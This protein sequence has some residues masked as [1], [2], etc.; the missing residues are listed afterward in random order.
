MGAGLVTVT[1]AVPADAMAAAG[2][3]AVNCVELTNVV[4]TAVPPKLTTEDERKPAPLTDKI[5]AG[6]P[7]RLLLGDIVEIVTAA[8]IV[9]VGV[10]ETGL[11]PGVEAVPLAHPAIARQTPRTT[12][13]RIAGPHLRHLSAVRFN[14]NGFPVG[15]LDFIWSPSWDFSK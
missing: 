4:A 3:T 15:V 11:A 8:G 10:V 12:R 14:S 9:G 13:A 7:A 1:V 5:N 2:T 6:L